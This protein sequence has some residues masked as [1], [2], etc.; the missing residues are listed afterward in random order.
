MEP[1]KKNANVSADMNRQ[2][3]CNREAFTLI[4]LLVV[5]AIIAIL[6]SLLLPALA[7][8]KEKA[9]QIQCLNN[10]KQ[11][12]ICYQ[13]YVT[14]NNDGLPINMDNSYPVNWTTNKAQLS[15]VPSEGITTGSLY[16]YNQN[17]K[18]Y[19]CPS[20]KKTISPTFADVFL[21]QQFY[22]PGITTS[23]QLPELR[24]CSIELSMGG[25][26]AHDP[27]GPWNYVS[28]GITWNTYWKMSQV[29]SPSRKIVFAQE[30]QST[31]QD[32]VFAIYPLVAGTPINVWFNVPGNRHNGGENF[33]F[34]DGHVEYRKWKSPDV[35]TYQDGNGGGGPYS[36]TAPYDDLYWLEAGGGQYP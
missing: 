23:S 5:I 33:S 34:G 15:V 25:N 9:R 18:I 26:Y 1:E 16:Q 27:T 36:S 35:V 17:Y 10:M 22:G 19:A 30:A 2:T 8:A 13:M 14:D 3:H 11:L 28:G 24:T 32:S 4:E 21:A 12:G 7:R 6:A 20:N 31:L 29:P